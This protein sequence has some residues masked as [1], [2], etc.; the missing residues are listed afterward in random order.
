MKRI[1][2]IGSGHLGQ[3]IAYHIQQDT[4][5]IAVAFFDDFQ[6]IGTL[7]QNIPVIGG[8]HEILKEFKKKTFDEILIAIGYK[9]IDFRKQMFIDLKDKI[10]F[11][12]FLHSSVHLD[13]SAKIGQGTVIYP[14]CVIDQRVEI[15]ENVLLNISCS[16]SHD[17]RIGSNSF[18]SPS[19][20]V[21]GFVRIGE[22][23]IVGI[24]STIIDNINITSETQIGGGTVV[25]K[26]IEIPGL[27]VG[28]PARFI[29]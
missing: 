1:A 5:D 12:T 16:I 29:R 27:Y 8:N 14:R 6:K 20:A 11:Y 28:N 15:G 9:H 17:T 7:I 21:A 22:Q 3:Q 18:L 4:E 25:I 19:V 24:N 23:C 13:P 2:I 10:P 26:D